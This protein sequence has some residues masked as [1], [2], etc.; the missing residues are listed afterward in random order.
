M[1]FASLI[2]FSYS[3]CTTAKNNLDIIH[4]IYYSNKYIEKDFSFNLEGN[5]VIIEN[6]I[7]GFVYKGIK[8]M[9]I[10]NGISLLKVSNDNSVIEVESIISKDENMSLSFDTHDI[11]FFKPI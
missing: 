10:S 7:F 6:N 8:I 11:F 1:H 2:I 3:N 5:N 4:E 9:N